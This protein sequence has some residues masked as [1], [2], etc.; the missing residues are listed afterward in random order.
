M[1]GI[2]IHKYQD[3]FCLEKASQIQRLQGVIS[4]FW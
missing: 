1:L 4:S 2:W 3:H